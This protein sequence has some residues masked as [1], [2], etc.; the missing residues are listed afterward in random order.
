MLCCPQNLLVSS[1]VITCGYCYWWAVVVT[2]VLVMV[3]VMVVVYSEV[4]VVIVVIVVVVVLVVFGD[5]HHHCS[6]G[7]GKA[8][9]DSAG[10]PPHIK[11]RFLM[12]VLL[13]RI[14]K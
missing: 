7:T 11:H 1:P 8:G 3:A 13:V 6:D 10:N 2:V 14:I 9:G 12:V 4:V 5:D